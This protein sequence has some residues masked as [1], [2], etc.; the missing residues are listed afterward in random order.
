MGHGNRLAEGGRIDRDRPIAFTFNGKRYRG[1][2]GDTLASALL[3]NAVV[4]V[5]R[6]FKYH[7]PRGIFTAGGEE[8]SAIVQVGTGNATQP[9]MKATEVEL[10]DGLIASSVNGWPSLAF[11]LGA[12]ADF[13]SGLLPAGFYYKTF[14]RPKG[15]W[16]TAEKVMRH[17]AGLGHAPPG[18]DPERYER[19]HAH[20][21]VLI[22]GAGPAGLAAALAAAR[23]GARVIV[24]DEQPEFGGSLLNE[25]IS[26]ND[27]PA[28]QWVAATVKDLEAAD[29]VRLL[30]SATVFGYY[31]HNLV[32]ILERRG[33]MGQRLWKVRAKQVVLSTGAIERPIAFA[34]ND[35]P[36]V[37]L[38]GAARAY[39]NR[40][41]A[42]PGSRA[43][44]FTNNDD[45][46]RTALDLAD[47]G[48]TVAAVIDARPDPD[49]PLPDLVSARD[50]A[51]LDRSV[52]VAAR[53]FGRVAG[54]DI[55]DLD[56]VN[57]TVSGEARRIKCDLLCVSGGWNPAVHL[58]SQSG[59]KVRYDAAAA[60][61][62]PG[63]AVQP[64]FSAGAANGAFHTNACL[65]EGA[66]AGIR[67][68]AAAGYD[69]RGVRRPPKAQEMDEQPLRPLWMVPP[70]K[71]GRRRGK[72]FVDLQTDV[73]TADVA[74]A[75]R[76]GYASVEHLKR[77]TGLGMG[78]DQGKTGNV[79]GLALLARE[80][81]DDIESVGTTTFRPPYAPVPMG[82]LA[83][84]DVGDLAEPAR[85]TPL[86]QWHRRAG[87][88][89]EDAGR[90]RRPSYYPEGGETRRQAIDR[91]CLAAR[92]AVGLL[93][94]S[95]L[96]KIDV[97]GRDAAQ[98]LDRIYTNDWDGLKVGRCRYGLMLGE[99]GM[100]MDDGVTLRLADD[101]FLVS[102]TSGGADAVLE[103]MEQWLQGEWP[104][105]DV[106]LTAVTEQWATLTVCG[107]LARPLLAEIS[108][109]IDLE[110][111]P[112]MSFQDGTV[113]GIPARLLRLGFLGEV[114]FEVNVPAGSAT[115]LW[116]TLTTVGER[117]GVTPFGVEALSVLR[118]E[119]GHFIV[120]QETDGTVTPGDL[121][122]D[123]LVGATTDFIGK[124]S[125]QR[126]DS[127]RLD[128]PHLVGLLTE[129]PDEVL[130]E[131]AQIVAEPRAKPPVPMIGHVTS[132]Y[133]SATLD[134]SIAL[135]L[136]NGG[137]GRHGE[138]VHLPLGDRTVRAVVAS[139]V[140]HDPEGTRLHG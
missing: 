66:R 27:K 9:C 71:A 57:E 34:N 41:A 69:K 113:A 80:L 12:A 64:Q 129:K 67:A 117:Y 95:T 119:K 112:F 39:V 32:A 104:D 107:P 8:P 33:E 7:R 40:Y 14:L 15:V 106:H 63:H 56:A 74:L 38:A 111:F 28:D 82:A 110:A 6:S 88:V 98:F 54:V 36:G 103:W 48:V 10:H 4:T 68:A 60:C 35:L 121:G 135:A 76:E 92:N 31:D 44:I 101:H 87:A 30:P 85:A 55:M 19:M 86:H 5:G 20:C 2:V 115:A 22:V 47:A 132:S 131:G 128:R 77:Y 72:A 83:G 37:M 45:A 78:T 123:R 75:A 25:K 21:D 100:V 13:F 65:A 89:F 84:R 50:I 127:V 109:D 125:L 124:R 11:D 29:E 138:T 81:G 79:V 116:T 139:P 62:V 114:C 108:A 90:W 96:G 53:G 73:T 61:F 126:A 140:F 46:Y 133:F 130:P 18:P 23:T 97:H 105:L 93:D 49:G 1:Y 120:G 24:A 118:A 91:E 52:V 134:R 42:K 102:T 51:V 3:A 137:R 99:D 59:G 58:F 70:D 26:L 122:M 43:V 16:K 94:A 17:A 136:L